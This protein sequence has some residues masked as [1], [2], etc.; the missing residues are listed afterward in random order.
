MLLGAI[1]TGGTKFV[2]AVGNE[3]GEVIEE[4]TIPTT[5]PDETMPKIFQFLNQYKI[6]GIGV[7]S[8]G[9]IDV[10]RQSPTYGFITTTPKLSWRHYNFV[11]ALKEKFSVPVAWTTDVNVAGY[12]E[13]KLG[14]AK[15]TESCL[16]LT[17]GTGIGGGFIQ[18]GKILNAYGH[19]EMGH[20]LVKRHPDDQFEGMCLYHHDCLEGLASGPAVEKRW[21][22]KGVEL[23]TNPK[24]WELEAYYIAQALVSYTLVLR[25][26][27]IILGGGIMNQKQIFQF[28]R[29]QFKEMLNGY[30]D[31]PDVEKYIQP[32]GLQNKAGIIGGLL[33]AKEEASKTNFVL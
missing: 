20:L 28:I 4:I 33:L 12:G 25:P 10:N 22:K 19:P 26:E 31:V 15:G 13:Y 21:G 9:P 11:G 24:V 30:V 8:F 5:T 2:A 7:G 18:S 23:S 16:Y 29:Q 1:E 14:N 6:E 17:I 3:H 32:V 27:R